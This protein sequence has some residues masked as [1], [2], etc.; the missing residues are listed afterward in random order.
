MGEVITPIIAM[1]SANWLRER[2]PGGNDSLQ[3]SAMRRRFEPTR[4]TTMQHPCSAALLAFNAAAR[5]NIGCDE[6]E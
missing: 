6:I 4:A 1:K 2:V 5:H 3:L